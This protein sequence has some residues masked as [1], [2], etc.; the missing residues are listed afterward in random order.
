MIHAQH[1]TEEAVDNIYCYILKHLR[2]VFVWVQCNCD[3]FL[4]LGGEIQQNAIVHGVCGAVY[5]IW[6]CSGTWD[7]WQWCGVQI[8]EGHVEVLPVSS[9][10]NTLSIYKWSCVNTRLVNEAVCCDENC[11]LCCAAVAAD[12]CDVAGWLVSVC[13]SVCRAVTDYRSMSYVTADIN[14]LTLYVIRSVTVSLNLSLIIVCPMHCIA[15]LDG[16]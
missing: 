2:V 9:I 11:V 13:L 8:V 12:H 15:A 7:G 14:R 4:F 10:F 3:Y 5:A 16:I 1:L 6:R